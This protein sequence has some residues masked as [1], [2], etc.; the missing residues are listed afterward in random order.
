MGQTPGKRIVGLLPLAA[1]LLQE[2][3][4]LF[5]IMTGTQMRLQGFERLHLRHRIG[6]KNRLAGFQ[7]IPV[8]FGHQP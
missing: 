5:Q 8:A 2:L 4:Q 7:G 3:Q 1:A 6:L